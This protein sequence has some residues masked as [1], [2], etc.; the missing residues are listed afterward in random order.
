MLL[1]NSRCCSQARSTP[2]HLGMDMDE[3]SDQHIDL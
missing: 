2:R 1:V 3:D